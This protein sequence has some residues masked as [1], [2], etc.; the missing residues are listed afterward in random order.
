MFKAPKTDSGMK[1]SAKGLLRV[2]FEDGN[3]VLYEQQTKE[4][5]EQG[6]LKTVFENGKLIVNESF[7]TIRNRL[8]S[9]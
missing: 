5:E 3:F 8:W 4:Q 6:C 7:D 9:N 1:N 2:E